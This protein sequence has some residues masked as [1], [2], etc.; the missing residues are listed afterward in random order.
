M[1]AGSKINLM[2]AQICPT[3]RCDHN[4]FSRVIRSEKITNQNKGTCFYWYKSLRFLAIRK[5]WKHVFE[6]SDQC[7][8]I[9]SSLPECIGYPALDPQ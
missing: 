8:V 7:V 6:P 3:K 9:F 4:D 5:S 2:F 1:I